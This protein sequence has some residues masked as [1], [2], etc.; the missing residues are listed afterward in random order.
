MPT[1]MRSYWVRYQV[2]MQTPQGQQIG[3]GQISINREFPISDEKCLAEIASAILQ[4]LAKQG[5]IVIGQDATVSVLDWTRFEE[6][7]PILLAKAPL[8]TQ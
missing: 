2:V 4:T 3:Q 8:Q 6:A 1:V 5:R 7:S